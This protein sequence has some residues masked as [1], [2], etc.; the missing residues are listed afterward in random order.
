MVNALEIINPGDT[1]AGDE[2]GDSGG[3][4]HRHLAGGMMPISAAQSIRPEVASDREPA[5][6]VARAVLR[7]GP[8]C[9]LWI[10]P[11]CPHCGASHVHGGGNFRQNPRAL[12]RWRTPPCGAP[13]YR[14][15]AA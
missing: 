3:R 6:P 15:L 12:L 10:V 1:A 5:A 8:S 13:C 4:L 2:V 11:R 9:W 7:R 14:L